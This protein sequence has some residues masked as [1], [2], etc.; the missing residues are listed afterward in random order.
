V[1]VCL[2]VWLELRQQTTN[3]K[4]LFDTAAFR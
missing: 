1:F 4:E 3:I 2:V